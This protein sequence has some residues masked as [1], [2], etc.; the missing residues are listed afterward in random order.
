MQVSRK[1]HPPLAPIPG[2]ARLSAVL[3]DWDGVLVDSGYNF[4]RAYEMVFRDEGIVTSPREIYLREGEPTPRLLKAIFDRHHVRIDDAKIGDLVIR[5]RE[6][7]AGLAERRLFR[8]VPRLVQRLRQV[9]CRLGMVTG[10]SR[11]SLVRVLTEEQ[12]R[13]FDVIITADDALRGKPRPGTLSTGDP[14]LRDKGR[15]VSGD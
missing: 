12:A 4:Y 7:D 15:K 11:N 6:Y 3:W 2:A 9:G 5:R 1:L 13:W 14:R 10:S 8:S